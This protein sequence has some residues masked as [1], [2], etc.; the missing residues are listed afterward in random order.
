MH[1]RH[2]MRML[3]SKILAGCCL[4]REAYPLEQA[5]SGLEKI[6]A[7]SLRL[8]PRA[9]APLMAWPVVCGSAVAE[10]TRALTF[11]DAGLRVLRPRPRWKAELPALPPRYFA[12][13]QPHTPH[14]P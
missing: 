13:T 8:A 6:V 9:E 7:Q 4:R 1:P 3:K 14:H 12:L 11:Q 5:G 10:R 2:S